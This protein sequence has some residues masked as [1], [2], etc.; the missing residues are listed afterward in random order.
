M[1]AGLAL[2]LAVTALP[3]VSFGVTPVVP[4][5]VSLSRA[6]ATA[7]LRSHGFRVVE[8]PPLQS[9][10]PVGTVLVTQ[11]TAGSHNRRGTKVYIL[12]SR[13]T[14]RTALP[15]GT[16]LTVLPASGPVGTS[17]RVSGRGFRPH[18]SIRLGLGVPTIFTGG[19]PAILSVGG[20]TF[21]TTVVGFALADIQADAAGAFS[22]AT[23]AVPTFVRQSAPL[24]CRGHSAESIGPYGCLIPGDEVML[25]LVSSRG[26]GSECRTPW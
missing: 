5:V 1:V 22:G 9:T 8:V 14:P 21:G 13:G 15:T 23:F 25:P 12:I 6:A 10:V 2:L 20:S 19:G 11:P 26:G 18:E 7:R 24:L 4:D 3:A 16:S 17:V